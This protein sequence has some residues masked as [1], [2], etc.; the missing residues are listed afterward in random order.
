[1]DLLPRICIS[2]LERIMSKKKLFGILV[3]VMST[4]FLNIYMIKI[5]NQKNGDIVSLCV[6]LEASQENDYQVFQGIQDWNPKF[7]QTVAYR[8]KNNVDCLKFTLP[9]NVPGVRLD[10]G[11]QKGVHRIK[12]LF[13]SYKKKTWDVNLKMVATACNDKKTANQ[14]ESAVLQGNDLLI[15]TNGEDGYVVLP[16]PDSMSG[17]VSDMRR[18]SLCIRYGLVCILV[19]IFCVILLI[20]SKRCYDFIRELYQSRQLIFILS[21]NDFKT[22]F[23]GSFFGIFWAFVQPV[24]TILIYWFVFSVGFR[25]GGIENCPF[26]LWLTAGLV[27][28]FFFSDAWNGATGSLMEYSYLVKKVVFKIS[29]L[30]IVKVMSALF[31][32]LCFHLFMCI[33]FMLHGFIPDLYWIQFPYY[34]VCNF[35]LVLSLSYITCSIIPFF[36]DLGQIINIVL[37]VG[38]WMTPIMWNIEMI[39]MAW[40]WIMKINPMYYIVQGYRNSLS[41]KQWFWQDITW[42]IYFWGLMGALFIT[43]NI[44]FKRLRPHFADVL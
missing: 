27:P 26:V 17:E 1:M 43:G 42:T 22:K 28:W 15:K 41:M 35:A 10:F 23:A 25:S 3:V 31:V 4:I 14:I 9:N 21:K 39:P 38:V 30:P 19:D 40:R 24:I 2:D 18:K 20:Y 16:M 13:L 36:K 37:Q 8:E 33:L 12:R 5:A 11:A 34:M 29:V 6:E 32:S 7:A 44:I